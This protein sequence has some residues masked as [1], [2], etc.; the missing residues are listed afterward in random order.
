MSTR[1]HV[2]R[3]L[4]FRI[5]AM[6]M[7][8]VV[9]VLLIVAVVL[10]QSV[11]SHLLQQVDQSLRNFATY[12]HVQLQAHNYLPSTTPAGQMGQFFNSNGTQVGSSV[13]LQGF[14]ALIHV[15]ALGP[16]PRITTVTNPVF[17][18]LR[19]LEQQFGTG[20][21]PI[22]V[23]AQQIGQID[24]TIS[25][26]TLLLAVVL[27]ILA[28]VLA[29]LIWFI[30]GRAMKPV[31]AVRVAVAHISDTD[32]DERV[33][34]PGTG[35]ELERLVET[36]N[37]MLERL[38]ATIKRERRFVA[39][40]SH[41]L[42]NPIAGVRAAL[43]SGSGTAEGLRAGRDAALSALQHLQDLAEELL[44]LD[45][46]GHAELSMAA[47][48]VDL[49]EL[50]LMQA[51]QLRRNTPLEVDS[52][53]VSGG[54]VLGSEI[55]MMRIL[56]NLVS[57]AVRHADRRIAFSLTEQDDWVVLTVVDD[58]P[59]I[60]ED[61]REMVFE[62]FTRLDGHRNRSSG[63]AGLGLAI[64]RE[65]VG[66]YGGSVR[67]DETGTGSGACAVVRLPASTRGPTD[68]GGG[69][70]ALRPDPP[71]QPVPPAGAARPEGPWTAD[72]QV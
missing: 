60:P 61:K 17:G 3:S 71:A 72:A 27:P 35:D 68:P 21:A 45:T 46:V 11:K 13:N 26:L 20:S 22:L 6:A 24:Q 38:Q 39:D 63:G 53:K 1:L 65:I 7:V 50:V 28:V 41:E 52:S 34:G 48:P 12:V 51:E 32:L 5:T 30:V 40:A 16:V 33:V 25:S 62:R 29:A 37:R 54:Q 64:V 55:D 49:D 67:I 70:S 43:E 36:M 42:R 59:G 15:H 23:E 31:E 14:P 10:I 44:V 8:V 57:N 69:G 56:D 47:A 2:V 58:G 66:K 9:V 4:R 18:N 19:V